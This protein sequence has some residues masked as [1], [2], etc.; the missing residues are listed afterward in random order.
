MNIAIGTDDKA[1]IRKGPFGA[2]QYSLVL[3]ILNARVVA[4]EWRDND[5]AGEDK[6]RDRHG[7]PV[8]VIELLRDCGLSLGRSF[9]TKG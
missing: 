9:D 5:H 2:S 6:E 3:E 1:T 8:Q 7:H 4:R